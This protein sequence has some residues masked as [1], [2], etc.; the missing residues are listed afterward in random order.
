MFR[1]EEVEKILEQARRM[2]TKLEING[3]SGHQYRLNLPVDLEFVH[4]TEKKYHFRFPEDYVQFIT[5]VGDGG[6]GPGYGLFSFKFYSTEA[7][8]TREIEMRDSYLRGLFR[9][10]HLI[11]LELDDLDDF[12][13]PEEEYKQNPEKYFAAGSYHEDDYV[14][15]G[16][17][18]LGTY[19]CGR[20]YGVITSGERHGQIFIHDLEGAFE[21]KA[22]S[23]QAFYQDWLAFLLDTE[24]FQQKLEEW[25]RIKNR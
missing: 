3:V 22:Y 8:N 23:F 10:P 20:D 1:R 14:P 15:Y 7:K 4:E 24:R 12:C 16:F 9:D 18:H 17:F 25:R 2:D 19:G 11:P 5:E 6:A 13:V 21:L